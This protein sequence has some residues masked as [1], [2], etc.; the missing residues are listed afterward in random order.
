MACLLPKRCT[1]KHRAHKKSGCRILK[2]YLRTKRENDLKLL[3]EALAAQNL[4]VMVTY[5]K[6]YVYI[7]YLNN[8]CLKRYA[9]MTDVAKILKCNLF[10]LL[11]QSQLVNLMHYSD[12]LVE[13]GDTYMLLP[14]QLKVKLD[15]TS[16][17]CLY[18]LKL[19]LQSQQRIDDI[20]N[21]FK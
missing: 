8:T 11:N 18:E 5:K 7:S 17:K 19:Y 21:N 16:L 4:V 14:N 2:N 12:F 20:M 3:R 6:H 10:R 9:N 15:K 1:R 13:D